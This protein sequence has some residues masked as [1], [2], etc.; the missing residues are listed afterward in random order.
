MD[1]KTKQ[2]RRA[3][4]Y[5]RVSTDEQTTDGQLMR[6]TEVADRAG[7]E[8][9]STYDETVS[10][11]SK[12]RP[13]LDALMTDAVRRRFDVVMVFD[14]SRLGRS[15]KD[16]VATFETLRSLGVDLY[17]D[18]QGF[19]TTTPA[20]RMAMNMCAV[21]AEFEREMTIE[22][23]KVGMAKARANGKQIGRA[24]A[25]E[26][27]TT[28]IRA[29]RSDGMGMNRIAAQLRCGKGLAQRV[30]QEFDREKVDG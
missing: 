7:W 24:P 11:V 20:G 9:V 5:V 14:V 30:C 18:R 22:R 4:I 8:V 10:G 13:M 25:S 26:A 1:N 2:A 6:L 15:L 17:L 3:A 29:L 16:L 27:L 21:F 23:T 28:A 12:R 19:D